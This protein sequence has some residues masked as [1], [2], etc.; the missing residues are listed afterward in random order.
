[1]SPIVAREAVALGL[2]VPEVLAHRMARLW[3][4]GMTPSPRDHAELLRMTSEKVAAFYESWSA[5]GLALWRMNVQ[6][7]MSSL[8]WPWFAGMRGRGRRD[9]VAY[10]E[11]VIDTMLRAGLPPIR[12]RAVANARRLRRSAR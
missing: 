4:A 10:G 9:A 5:I 1:M 2:A 12:R 6:V 3:L 7:G 8:W 11:R